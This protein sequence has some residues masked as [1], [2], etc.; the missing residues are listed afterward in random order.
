MPHPPEEGSVT[1]LEYMYMYGRLA[2]SH[3][4]VMSL[5]I[6]LLISRS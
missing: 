2:K 1:T 4:F 6:S 5:T 3:D